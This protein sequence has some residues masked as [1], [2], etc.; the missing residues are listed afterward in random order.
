MAK[1]K[2][3]YCAELVEHMTSGLSFESFGAKVDAHRSTLHRWREKNPEFRD[4]Y[5]IGKLKSLYFWEVLGRS[6]ATGRVPSFNATSWIFN[7]KNR[8]DW[9]DNVSETKELAQVIKLAY[10]IDD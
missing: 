5:E 6:G 9:G 8:F 10:K 3:K 4:A 2:P 7:M 1:Y